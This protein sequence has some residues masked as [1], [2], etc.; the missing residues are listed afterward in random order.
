ML[1]RNLGAGLSSDLI[2]DATAETYRQWEKRYGLIPQERLRTEIKVA[3]VRSINPGA[4]YQLAG[5]ERGPVRRGIQFF[6]APK[7]L[8]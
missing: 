4:C 5:W 2:R 7:I 8:P 1:F 3:A 6:Y